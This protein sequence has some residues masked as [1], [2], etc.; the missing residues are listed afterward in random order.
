M[1]LRTTFMVGFPGEN[2]EQFE[3]LLGFVERGEFLHVGVLQ[4][5]TESGTL[6]AQF[7]NSIPTEVSSLRKE[8]IEM[9]HSDIL[10]RR[11]EKLQD[12]VVKSLV[13]SITMREGIYSA[14]MAEDAPQ[15]D[16]TIKVR[17]D[18]KIGQWANIRIVKALVSDFLGV[19][20]EPQSAGTPQF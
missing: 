13:D 9:T 11:N 7:P 14:R 1:A 10:L 17:G 8:L 19:V 20:D 12:K 5:S 4:Y 3:K 2:D 6:A 18:L 16:R 15:V